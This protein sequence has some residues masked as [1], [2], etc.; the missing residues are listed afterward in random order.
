MAEVSTTVRSPKSLSRSM[1]PTR[2]RGDA[3]DGRTAVGG[4]V[5]PHHLGPVH[6]G[7]V[8]VGLHDGAGEPVRRL[9]DAVR[10]SAIAVGSV[11]TATAILVPLA[12]P[13]FS[14]SVFDLGNG[15]GGDGDIEIA[16]PLV[17]LRRDLVQGEDIDLIRV[18]T[19]DPMPDHLRISVLN[20]FTD[21]EW[22]NGDRQVPTDNLAQGDLPPLEGVDDTIAPVG[23]TYD[24]DV[25][26]ADEFKSL[27]LPTMAPLSRIVADGDWRFD[28][29]TMDFLSSDDDLTTAGQSYQMTGEEL[30]YNNEEL[31]LLDANASDVDDE[32]TELPDGF[33]TVVRQLAN[34]VTGGAPTSFAKAIAL[35]QWFRTTGGFEYSLERADPQQ[36]GVDE[37]EAFLDEDEGRV[38]YC[39]QFAAAMAVMARALDIPSRVAV[40]FLKPDEDPQNLGTWVYSARD[41]HA[42][43]ELYFPGAGWVQFDP[44]PADRVGNLVPGYSL[45]PVDANVPTDNPTSTQTRPTQT[46]GPD[47]IEPRPEPTAGAADSAGGSADSDGGFPWVRL[48]IGLVLVALVVVLV[49]LPRTLRE[50]QRTRRLAG[51]P[52]AVWEELRATLVDLRL[53]WP[54]RRSPQETRDLVVQHFG[55]IGGPAE[56]ETFYER[57]PTGP[58]Q[59]PEAVAALDRVVDQVERLRYS[60]RHT[61]EQGALR[62]DVLLCCEALA[63]GVTPRVRRSAVWLPRSVAQRRPVDAPLDA[64]RDERESESVGGVVEHI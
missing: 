4:A 51:G 40:G 57:P 6:L 52:E 48:L 38:G 56:H 29:S 13:T 42:W 11:A 21:N 10:G 47:P 58:E 18:T 59:A 7:G 39:E 55:R 64:D 1:P 45:L 46:G 20:R 27:W 63:A 28:D 25:E 8:A 12:I 44:T 3:Q 53:V 24:Y 22:S 30:A 9:S 19:D 41:L 35:Q 37:L 34:E 31:L 15:P 2:E 32:L 62:D 61:A 5:Q 23:R 16:N 49:W 17:D 26:I 60:R 43:V 14:L 50:R 36:I 33:S 54:E